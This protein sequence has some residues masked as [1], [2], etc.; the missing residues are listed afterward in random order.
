[1]TR[2]DHSL[3]RVRRLVLG[4]LSALLVTLAAPAVR[5]ETL[6]VAIDLRFGEHE[7]W[8]RVVVDF[9]RQVPFAARAEVDPS[10]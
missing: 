2:A 9:D 1:M 8:T 3:S 5:V 7:N 4:I 6:P 10:R